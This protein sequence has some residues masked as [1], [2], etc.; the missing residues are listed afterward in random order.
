LLARGA[1]GKAFSKQSEM[2]RIGYGAIND[3]PV[4]AHGVTNDFS[5]K[6]KIKFYDYLYRHPI[7][8]YETPLRSAMDD[9]GQYF[10]RTDRF[11]PW[12]TLSVMNLVARLLAEKLSYFN[13]RWILERT[14][15]FV[16]KR[17]K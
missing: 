6:N 5:H 10:M 9:V 3:I 13:D 12:Q 1:I 7:G 8:R 16:S 4:V 2:I 17:R 11:G 14:I 15:C